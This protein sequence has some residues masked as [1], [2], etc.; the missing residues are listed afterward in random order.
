MATLLPQALKLPYYSG[1]PEKQ[2]NLLLKLENIL[3]EHMAEMLTHLPTQQIEENYRQNDLSAERHL[4]ALETLTLH[5]HCS[6]TMVKLLHRVGAHARADALMNSAIDAGDSSALKHRIEEEISHG[7]YGQPQFIAAFNILSRIFADDSASHE[8]K[9]EAAKQMTSLWKNTR[10]KTVQWSHLKPLPEDM[11]NPEVIALQKALTALFSIS[12]EKFAD[13]AALGTTL[14]DISEELRITLVGCDPSDPMFDT[15]VRYQDMVNELSEEASQDKQFQELV[16]YTYEHFSGETPDTVSMSELLE[17]EKLEGQ[18]EIP[19]LLETL[20]PVV[21]ENRKKRKSWS[22]SA[23]GV[24]KKATK[25]H[26]SRFQTA[27]TQNKAR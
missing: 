12:N 17:Q 7:K 9:D 18:V 20:T 4:A 14:D 23:I 19:D 25:K 6:A 26:R 24:I 27:G 8:M 2:I 21:V 22:A 15:L 13:P 16:N 11:T 5:H 10:N 3:P 1:K